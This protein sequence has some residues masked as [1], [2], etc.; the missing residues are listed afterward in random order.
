M[1]G[2]KQ[3]LKLF[4]ILLLL[5]SEVLRYRTCCLQIAIL[6]PK[7]TIVGIFWFQLS[8]NGFLIKLKKNLAKRMKTKTSP[9]L[10]FLH[11]HISWGS[12]TI[13]MVRVGCLHPLYLYKIFFNRVTLNQ[14]STTIQGKSSHACLEHDPRQPV[15]PFDFLPRHL[16]MSI[17]A[18]YRESCLINWTKLREPLTS[19]RPRLSSQSTLSQKFLQKN[20]SRR[21]K[22][23][24]KNCTTKY[25]RKVVAHA[26]FTVV[27]HQHR[28]TFFIE[29]AGKLSF[30]KLSDFHAKTGERKNLIVSL[31]GIFTFSLLVKLLK[32]F[33]L[34]CFLSLNL[35]VSCLLFRVGWIYVALF[36]KD[37][38]SL[39]HR[40][41][42]CKM[43]FHD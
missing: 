8:S 14:H 19:I 2:L 22:L 15:E 13:A 32:E 26:S 31:K 24:R 6:C 36:L 28:L 20:P 30:G 3:S 29:L 9:A 11:S 10:N 5:Y 12:F 1:N 34:I 38:E 21:S 27:S 43:I 42:V 17:K 40:V 35:I 4:K 23:R 39:L 18:I 25:K 37:V 33:S 41:F 7:F 16:L